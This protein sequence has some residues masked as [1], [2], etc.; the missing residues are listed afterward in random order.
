MSVFDKVKQQAQQLTGKAKEAA[1]QASGN[2]DLRDAGKRDRL[3]GETK[4][5]A[6]DVKDKAAGAAEDAKD[7]LR[8]RE[9]QDG[10]NR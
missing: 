8:G 3:A 4:E 1:G 5:Q 9:G 10:D 2:E 6:H 7:K